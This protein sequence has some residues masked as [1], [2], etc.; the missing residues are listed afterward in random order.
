MA[1]LIE[2][3]KKYKA[4]ITLAVLYVYVVIL[5]VATLKEL[6]II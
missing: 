2:T 5:G 3:L 1:G 4:E 6:G